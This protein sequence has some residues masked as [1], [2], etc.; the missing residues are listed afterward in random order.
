MNLSSEPSIETLPEH[1][2][3]GIDANVINEEIIAN[4]SDTIRELNHLTEELKHTDLMKTHNGH[5]GPTSADLNGS[6]CEN[7][8]G[9]GN[10]SDQDHDHTYAFRNP[11]PIINEPL[12]PK[13]EFGNC[14]V[15]DSS[16]FYTHLNQHS[17]I[18][19]INGSGAVV[20]EF[21]DSQCNGNSDINNDND[22]NKE[23]SCMLQSVD[24]RG[25][26]IS[27]SIFFNFF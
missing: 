13:I 15:V 16:P 24:L 1:Y 14:D 27:W 18:D 2:T 25:R 10:D 7:G 21:Y 20:R 6:V 8:N 9:D 19:S 22:Y 23:P 11:E 3:N 5:G 26:W 17:E 4:F 12:E